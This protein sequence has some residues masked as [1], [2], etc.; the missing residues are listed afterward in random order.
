MLRNKYFFGHET[1]HLPNAIECGMIGVHK[2]HHTL[3]THEKNKFH[4][5]YVL[6]LKE[7]STK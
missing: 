7:K 6:D 4:K 2:N 3:S 1:L 5:S